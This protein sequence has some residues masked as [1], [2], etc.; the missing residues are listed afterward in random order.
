[1]AMMA[2]T[3]SSSMSV[4]AP[5]GSEGFFMAGEQLKPK[6]VDHQWG[7]RIG[8]G[9]TAPAKPD[10]QVEQGSVPQN[11]IFVDCP[12]PAHEDRGL[13]ASMSASAIGESDMRIRA[14]DPGLTP[15]RFI[16]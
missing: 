9:L 2:I 16:R 1:M 4:K 12:T 11:R 8:I 13:R 6:A 10:K 7:S 15:F 14:T 3:T 5:L